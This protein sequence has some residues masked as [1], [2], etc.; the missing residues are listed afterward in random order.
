MKILTKTLSCLCLVV[1]LAAGCGESFAPATPTAT[2]PPLT[3]E[4][5]TKADKI[6]EYLTG[7]TE[8]GKFSGAVL[9]EYQGKTLVAK[10][11]G[12]ADRVNETPNTLQTRFVL[13]QPTKVF[14]TLAMMVLVEQGKINLQEPVCQY[15][16]GCPDAWKELKIYNLLN[17]SS[18]IQDY[19]LVTKIRKEHAAPISHQDLLALVK[20]IPI[21][22]Y[23][24]GY[25]GDSNYVILASII[26]KISGTTYEKF[27]HENVFEP[28]GLVNTG[29]IHGTGEKDN[30]AQYYVDA[31]LKPSED[32]HDFSNHFG[33]DDIYSSV[34]DINRMMKALQ[35]GEFLQK[36][37]REEM[38]TANDYGNTYGWVEYQWIYESPMVGSGS[39]TASF[40]MARDSSLYTIFLFNQSIAF[41]IIPILEILYDKDIFIGE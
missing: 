27:L 25:M 21:D 22:P 35:N 34:D 29:C 38:L 40:Q 9:I 8:D 3:Q 24:A 19:T 18:K 7:L 6:D 15:V 41:D 26:E 36:E 12:M 4:E 5:Q 31:S 17:S 16:D 39:S 33:S 28:L 32:T 11:Y 10:G 37:T 23:Y 14:T 13:Y 1:L 20:T 2:Y 30:L